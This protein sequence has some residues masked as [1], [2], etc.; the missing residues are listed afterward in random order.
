MPHRMTWGQKNYYYSINP[1]AHK[2]EQLQFLHFGV[3]L[4]RKGWHR[5][6][7]VINAM[8]LEKITAWLKQPKEKR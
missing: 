8:S 5:R 7:D 4:A 6:E 1:D 2:T 3:R